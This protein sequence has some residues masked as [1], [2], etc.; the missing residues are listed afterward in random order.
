MS[1]GVLALGIAATLNPMERRALVS[2]IQGLSSK[3][4]PGVRL[5][6]A[7]I[8]TSASI[9]DIVAVTN[10]V[11][12]LALSKMAN[13]MASNELDDV[14]ASLVSGSPVFTTEEHARRA[15]L[16]VD[17]ATMDMVAS[18]TKAGDPEVANA[19]YDLILGSVL[20]AGDSDGACAEG[21]PGEGDV[22][23]LTLGDIAEGGALEG[24]LFKKKDGTK[25][26]LFNSNVGAK[27]AKVAGNVALLS[28]AAAVLGLKG[29]GSTT[30]KSAAP[31]PVPAQPVA[32]TPIRPGQVPV[33]WDPAKWW[34]ASKQ[35]TAAESLTTTSARMQ[36]DLTRMIAAIQASEAEMRSEAAEYA[37]VKRNYARV[38]TA[39]SALMMPDQMANLIAQYPVQ[40]ESLDA[41][42]IS[43]LPYIQA[44]G[45]SSVRE[46]WRNFS[47]S[48]KSAISGG[49]INLEQA[50]N[51]NAMTDVFGKAALGGGSPSDDWQEGEYAEGSAVEDQLSIGGRFKRPKIGSGLK[52]AIKV[53]SS[54]TP[55]GG[56]INLAKAAYDHKDEVAGFAKKQG[57]KL[58]YAAAFTPLG[59]TALVAN[60]LADGTAVGRSSKGKVKDR[61]RHGDLA[62]DLAGDFEDLNEALSAGDYEEGAPT[63][64]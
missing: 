47:S 26:K 48:L 30:V 46:W 17:P 3:A 8:P 5:G 14:S 44:T 45:N 61:F 7:I 2:Q 27:A 12:L 60:D 25:R 18:F 38:M 32:T 33:G 54:F 64:E 56:T 37:N 35:P 16:T 52:K 43:A 59:A 40:F 39:R 62:D 63:D 51:N 41:M 57:G 23:Y 19:A 58:K 4:L 55:V 13:G 15:G 21:D 42:T 11:Q 6:R 22:P 29:G 49:K 36:A 24:G 31:A 20:G 53:A 1:N 50:V 34:D 28:P 9:D 10:A